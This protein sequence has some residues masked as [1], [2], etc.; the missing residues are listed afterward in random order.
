MVNKYFT[1]QSNRVMIYKLISQ[2]GEETFAALVGTEP[3]DKFRLNNARLQMCQKRVVGRKTKRKTNDLLKK[4]TANFSPQN[5]VGIGYTD[6][7]ATHIF[8]KWQEHNFYAFGK[9]NHELHDHAHRSETDIPDKKRP[10]EGMKVLRRFSIHP[11]LMVNLNKCPE[12][13]QEI[14]KIS[15]PLLLQQD[16]KTSK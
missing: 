12:G 2:V 4:E 9:N 11:L 16:Q 15:E 7:Q 6:A 8:H 14:L 10:F 1:V 13:M 3:A 5:K